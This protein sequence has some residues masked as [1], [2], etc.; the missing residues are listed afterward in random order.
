VQSAP[1][2]ERGA[3]SSRT[4]NAGE[5]SRERMM[6]AAGNTL[7]PCLV[8]SLVRSRSGAGSGSQTQRI[9]MLA[10]ERRVIFR[11]KDPLFIL[12][13]SRVREFESFRRRSC[14]SLSAF[15]TQRVCCKAMSEITVG[16]VRI[17]ACLYLRR[18]S[19]RQKDIS[20]APHRNVLHA[21]RSS[22]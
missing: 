8:G 19:A 22:S 13:K 17:R 12:E 5:H 20:G 11:R 9:E 10:G 4:L 15:P 18:T 6:E 2:R 1:N 16:D 14:C 7:S 21:G 3:R